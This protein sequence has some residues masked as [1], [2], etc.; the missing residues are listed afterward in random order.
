MESFLKSAP[1]GKIYLLP[2]LEIENKGNEPFVLNLELISTQVV[3]EVDGEDAYMD[4]AA[5]IAGIVEGLNVFPQGEKVT[6]EPGEKVNGYL[7]YCVSKKWKKARICIFENEAGIGGR[8]P[9]FLFEL[10]R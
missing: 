7:P 9:G 3:S 4:L 6:V 1:K 10:T 5:N 8:G 2:L